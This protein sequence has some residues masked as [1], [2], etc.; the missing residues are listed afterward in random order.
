MAKLIDLTGQRFGRLVVIKYLG[1]STWQCK[2]DC[3]N[4]VAVHGG[5]L[6]SHSTQSC[7]CLQKERTSSSNK[8][9]GL[10]DHPVYKIACS[11]VQRCT[12]KNNSAYKNYGGRGVRV[13]PLWRDN[14]GLFAKWLLDNGWYEGCDIDKDI[15][16]NADMP[17]Y[18]PNTISFVSRR[19]NV[20]HTRANRYIEY[21]GQQKSLSEWCRV[22]D[23][24][25]NI[26]RNRYYH[27][28]WTD[29]IKLFETP[30]KARNAINITYN[31]EIKSLA[32]WC[33]QLNLSYRSVYSR[34]KRGWRDPHDLFE[35]PI[36]VGNNQTLRSD[37]N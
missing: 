35:R 20:N 16:G 28:H 10:R 22:L 11:I 12:N 30:I 33:K 5:N 31:G 7:G 18:F 15:K 25:V 13:Y 6:K 17:G 24:P 8:K 1:K 9:H 27:M 23:L 14:V 19:N 2:C 34:Y 32:N 29:P 36:M 26:I 37:N 4:E 21:K 3:G